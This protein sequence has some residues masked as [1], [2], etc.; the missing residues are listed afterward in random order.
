MSSDD[1]TSRPHRRGRSAVFAAAALL[2][3]ASV[4]GAC[5]DNSEDGSNGATGDQGA[6]KTTVTIGDQGF[7][8]SKI[9]AHIYGDVLADKGVTVRYQS[10]KDR[11]ASYTALE[12]GDIDLLPDYAASALEFLNGNAGEATPSI[13]ETRPKLVAA[14]KSKNL[15]AADASPAVDTNSL[16]VTKKTSEDKGITTISQLTDDLRLGGPQDCP[17]NAGCLPA[18]KSKY[19]IDLSK[20]FQPLDLS[21]PLT[22]KALENGDIDVAVIFSTDSTIAAKDWVVLTDDKGIF[23][24]DNV[25]PVGTPKVINT[26]RTTLDK[27]SEAI[28]TAELTKLNKRFDVDKDD[29]DDIAD[30]FVDQAKLGD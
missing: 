28:T 15:D 14:L 5:G 20:N 18:L 24:A 7:G 11:K 25:I 16:V 19:G 12:H 8:E 3:V 27:V 30:D 17:T 9:L 6:T 10:F 21:G 4:L 2:L 22:K 29:A 1:R 23:M 26:Y 13:D